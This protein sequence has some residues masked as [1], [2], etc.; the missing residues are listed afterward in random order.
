M[1]VNRRLKEARAAIKSGSG[2]ED[3]ERILLDSISLP[4]TTDET[5]AEGYH[6]CA[7]LEQSLND[8]LNMS[9]YLKQNI[10]TV[11]LY[12]TI[13]NIYDH[14]LRSDSLD[15]KGRFKGKNC[16]LRALHRQNLLGGGKYH[17]RA[18]RWSDAYPFF[19][20][21]LKTCTTDMDSVVGRVAY[22]A[23]VCGMNENNPHHVL[24]HV[25]TAIALMPEQERPA[26]AEYKARSCVSLGDSAQWLDV[27]KSG[28]DCYPGYNY[29][30]LNLMDYYMRHGQIER[31]MAV[32]DS[33]V[34]HDGDRAVYWFAL[35]LF[36]L[37]AEDYEKCIQMSEECLSREP[38][39]VD[40]LYNK[41]ISLLNMALNEKSA[42]RC[43]VLYRRALE[44]MER[45]RE[46][47]PDDLDRWGNPLYRIYLNLNMGRKF[48]EIDSLLLRHSNVDDSEEGCG[49]ASVHVQNA[50]DG[51]QFID[52]HFGK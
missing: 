14:T 16:K 5:K 2:Q 34:K 45:V 7:L 40:A 31:G 38:D 29:F 4:T 3:I 32:T 15:D 6:L 18:S 8:G 39:N 49:D 20:R 11:R 22:W 26:L 27:L 10:D 42:T 36:A 13:L 25:D 35:S 52:K 9:A 28:V 1:T 21:F 46:L 33:L 24:C 44:P 17:L 23:T 50:G 48:E 30:F 12:R 41:G 37:N 43:R 19:D 47:S 51:K